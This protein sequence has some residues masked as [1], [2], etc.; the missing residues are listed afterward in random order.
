MDRQPVVGEC[1]IVHDDSGEHAALQGDRLVVC[2]V[3]GSDE[4]LRGVR[5]GDNSPVDGWISWHDVEPIAFGWDY[6]RRHLPAEVVALLSACDGPH[7]LSLNLRIKE[8]IVQ[9][10]PDWKSRVLEVIASGEP[11]ST[12]DR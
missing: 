9:A 12:F 2:E 1:V 3:D 8:A 7:H 11:G 6:A 4:T 10:L 5:R